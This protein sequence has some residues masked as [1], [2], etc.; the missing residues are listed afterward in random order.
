LI[1]TENAGSERDVS[2]QRKERGT[3]GNGLSYGKKSLRKRDTEIGS[4]SLAP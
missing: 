3:E 1:R 4:A 2:E